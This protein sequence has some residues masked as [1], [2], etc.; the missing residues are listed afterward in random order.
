MLFILLNYQLGLGARTPENTGTGNF[1]PTNS[2]SPVLTQGGGLFT[3]S[4]GSW[5]NVP[6][7]YSYSWFINGGITGGQTGSG[8]SETLVPE[9]SNVYSR[10][11]AYNTVGSGSANSNT[12]RR[13]Y[14]QPVN[15]VA[16]VASQSGSQYVSTTGTWTG[17]ITGW[18]YQWKSDGSNIS[19][20][21]GS[22][23][24]IS[25]LTE[26][27]SVLC[28]V[29]A[30]NPDYSIYANS[31]AISVPY[32]TPTNTVAPVNSISGT[33]F[34]TTNGTW[35]G[36]ITGYSYNWF[37]NGTGQGATSTGTSVAYGGFPQG[38]TVYCRVGG[39]NPQNSGFANSNSLNVPYLAPGNTVAP[40][41]AYS[42]NNFAVTSNGTWTGTVNG[43][44]Y[45][46]YV[47]GAS[48][49]GTGASLA[50]GVIAQDSD[51]YCRVGAYNT[52]ATGFANSN[53]LDV[54]MT[55]PVNTVA[56]TITSGAG[57]YDLTSTGSWT[58]TSI[59]GFRYQWLKNSVA[60]GSLSTT[61]SAFP[62]GGLVSGD[63]ISYRL[64]AYNEDASGSGVSNSLT[65]LL[66]TPF[67]APVASVAPTISSGADRY[68]VSNTGTWT[69][70]VDG[71]AYQWFKNSSSFAGQTGTGLLF[72][73]LT[74]NDSVYCQVSKYNIDATGT[75]NSNN[76][77][78]L[79]ATGSAPVNTSAPTIAIDNGSYYVSNNGTWNNSPTGYLYQW[80]TGGNAVAGQTGT[81]Y[82]ATGLAT[83]TSVQLIVSG[84][85]AYGTGTGVSAGSSVPNFKQ[86]YWVDN[87]DNEDGFRYEWGTGSGVYTNTGYAGIDAT[88]A[89]IP[90]ATTGVYYVRVIAYNNVTGSSGASNVLQVTV[91]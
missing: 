80:A 12:I 61:N 17:T 34:T 67:G 20:A 41:I 46:W 28:Q 55:A 60:Q 77:T 71:T 86:V 3:S 70:Q 63:Q 9:G 51:V 32:S 45:N 31:N 27:A 81:G 23:V 83:G 85:N 90:F 21:T 72:T 29:G 79:V 40:T 33:S 14:I 48:G 42:G 54:P 30:L 15:T 8:I 88:G 7:G 22:G 64:V 10:V 74:A 53:T 19:N 59:T 75:S 18:S 38:A 39:H 49:A 69:G 44:R 24:N 11:T 68:Y 37:I 5:T 43:Y 6:T 1:P 4:R 16:P 25:S 36:T 78:Y 87:A 56:P 65:F 82:L 58:G 50:F 76:L 47:N 62:T 26:G 2:V 35:T 66:R 84:R 91:P 13:G 57:Q 52:D 73:D 89:I